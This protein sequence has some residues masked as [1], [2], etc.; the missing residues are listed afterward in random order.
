MGIAYRVKALEM[1]ARGSLTLLRLNAICGSGPP[2]QEHLCVSLRTICLVRRD[3]AYAS[4]RNSD[5]DRGSACTSCIIFA[6]QRERVQAREWPVMVNQ[7]QLLS[8]T[9]STSD[10]LSDSPATYL[11]IC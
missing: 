2:M 7:R 6:I 5:K 11:Y 4:V 8:S 3:A 10:E 1:T 9:C